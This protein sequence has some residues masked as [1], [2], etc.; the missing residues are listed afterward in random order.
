MDS[1]PEAF[2]TLGPK[3]QSEA[4][5]LRSRD[6]PLTPAIDVLREMGEYSRFTPP[7]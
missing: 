2:V 3:A 5:W 6:I 4:R 1:Y 7:P